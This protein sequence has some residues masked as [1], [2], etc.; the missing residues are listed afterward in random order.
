[1]R[2]LLLICVSYF[3]VQIIDYNSK[4]VYVSEIFKKDVSKYRVE[5]FIDRIIPANKNVEIKVFKY[6][7]KEK[8]N[9]M[10]K[11]TINNW[12]YINWF[13]ISFKY[14]TFKWPLK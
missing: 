14:E 8:I 1:M 7:S 10:R 6:S 11:Q 12:K 5:S 3:F 13:P 9:R 4:K 2:L